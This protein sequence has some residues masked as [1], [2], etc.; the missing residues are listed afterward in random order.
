MEHKE[1]IIQID[2]IISAIEQLI[3]EYMKIPEDSTKSNG[4]VAVCIIDEDG[5]VYG[6]MYGKN[7]IIS[8]RIYKIAWTKA[9]QVWITSMKTGEY[10]KLVFNKQIDESIYG[11]ET[12]DLIGWEGG[13]PVTLRD[14]TKLS[15]GFSGFRGI[16]D[17]SIVVNA[18]M[19]INQI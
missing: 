2:K 4:N 13:Q 1:H 12:P 8:R 18:L 7:K 11:I 9:S 15:V 14:G 17:I 16:S 10:E 6:K 3:P 5:N 19:N